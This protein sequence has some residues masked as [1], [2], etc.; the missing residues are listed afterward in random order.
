MLFNSGS[1]VFVSICLT[2][3]SITQKVKNF[4]TNFLEI[5]IC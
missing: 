2:V 3:I 1:C 4:W 5:V